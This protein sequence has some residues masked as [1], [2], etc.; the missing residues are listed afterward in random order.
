MVKTWFKGFR[1][2]EVQ[3]LMTD[4]ETKTTQDTR[5]YGY[6]PDDAFDDLMTNPFVMTNTGAF[7]IFE[8]VVPK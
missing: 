5:I 8:P 7:V 4:P 1:N 3:T 2:P 6:F